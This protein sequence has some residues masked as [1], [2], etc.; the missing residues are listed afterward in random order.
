MHSLHEYSPIEK[1]WKKSEPGKCIDIGILW[2]V[3]SA[4]TIT[5]DLILIAM[6][7]RQIVRL[8]LPLSQ[9]LGLVLIFSLGG[10]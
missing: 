9:K 2:Y 4:M 3:N 7:I 6:P 8:K 1:A 10:L 5:A